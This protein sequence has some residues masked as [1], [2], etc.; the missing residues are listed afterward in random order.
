MARVTSRLA[1]QQRGVKEEMPSLPSG[2]AT[3]LL[4][5]PEERWGGREHCC[6]INIRADILLL[7]VYKISERA[8]KF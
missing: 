1:Q 3:L 2:A 7:F 5:L 8:E 4:R 6:N